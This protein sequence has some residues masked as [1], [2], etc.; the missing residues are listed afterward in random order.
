M[1]TLRTRTTATGS[2]RRLLLATGVLL[3]GATLFAGC[4]DA[5]RRYEPSQPSTGPATWDRDVDPLINTSAAHCLNCHNP[6]GIGDQA[7]GYK[8]NTY[9]NALGVD[10][11]GQAQVIP[12]DAN[13]SPL[14]W[15]LEGVTDT[16]TPVLIRMPLDGGPGYL[17]QS[18]IDVFRRW[19][20]GGALEY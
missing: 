19:I 9:A 8:L 17:P 11:G 12:G 10:G 7:T 2:S 13:R 5:F 14:I 16:G 20:D 4:F 3:G 18:T 1:R 15:R 6:G